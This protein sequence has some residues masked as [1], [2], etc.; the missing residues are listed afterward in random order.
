MLL[1]LI[2]T[3]SP[4]PSW[5]RPLKMEHNEYFLELNFNLCQESAFLVD[6]RYIYHLFKIHSR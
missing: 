4:D 1:L 3:L 6:N 5:H 2:N